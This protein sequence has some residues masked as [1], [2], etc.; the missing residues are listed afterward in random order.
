MG[1]GTGSG[2]CSRNLLAQLTEMLGTILKPPRP[3]K[4]NSQPNEELGLA[5]VNN[6]PWNVRGACLS[7]FLTPALLHPLG[8]V[9]YV[10]D[11]V[12]RAFF[13]SSL[14]WR[15]A[16]RDAFVASGV[17][18]CAFFVN[19]SIKYPRWYSLSP[20]CAGYKKALVRATS[21]P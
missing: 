15:R 8:N 20:S 19:P 14:P 4:I 7:Y 16:C 5:A 3:W 9:V 17:Q 10:Q 1:V 21:L 13:L 2:L 12:A 18:L 11:G 6:T